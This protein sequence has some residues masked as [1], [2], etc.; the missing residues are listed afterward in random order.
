M[1]EG[2]WDKALRLPNSGCM[3]FLTDVIARYNLKATL[4]SLGR[5]RIARSSAG[6]CP[7]TAQCVDVQRASSVGHPSGRL[8]EPEPR[9]EQ[10]K[11]LHFDDS[12]LTP[13]V[14]FF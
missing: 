4:V 14:R 8:D 11:S 3:R 7:A 5:R 12:R 2:E 1:P 9:Y 6:G 10:V 13:S